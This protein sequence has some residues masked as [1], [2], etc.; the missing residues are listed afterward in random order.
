[1]RLPGGLPT[2][3]GTGGDDEWLLA[4]CLK[5]QYLMEYP[6]A[7]GMYHAEGPVCECQFVTI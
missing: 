4:I 5:P 1:M 6:Y 3:D 7:V 2:D